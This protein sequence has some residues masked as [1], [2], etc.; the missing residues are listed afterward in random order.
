MDK[1]YNF[2]LTNLRILCQRQ[3]KCHFKKDVIISFLNLKLARLGATISEKMEG[4]VTTPLDIPALPK[5][6]I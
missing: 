2:I 6:K 5:V 4:Y 1:I 3:W